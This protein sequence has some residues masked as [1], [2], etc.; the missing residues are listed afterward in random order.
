L[1][2][3]YNEY[4]ALRQV[5]GGLFPPGEHRLRLSAEARPGFRWDLALEVDGHEVGGIDGVAMMVGLA[6]LEGIDV[7]IDRRSPVH[8]EVYERHGPFPYTGRLRGV[9]YTP[10]APGPYDPALVTRATVESARAYD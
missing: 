5:D 2:L 7:G 3:V 9:T 6:P 4:G 8:W 1:Q 10:G